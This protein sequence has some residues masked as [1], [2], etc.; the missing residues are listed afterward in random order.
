[1]MMEIE[2]TKGRCD[3]LDIEPGTYALGVVHDE[4]MNGKM[5]TNWLGV[6]EE[7]YGFSSGAKVSMSAP[8]FEDA[9]FSYDGKELH[10]T[11]GLTY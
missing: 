11:I 10:L 9:S 5:D 1:M 8:S 2:D 6:P 4:N 3:F 7:G